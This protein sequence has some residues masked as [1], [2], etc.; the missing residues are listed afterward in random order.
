M[1]GG[2][3][4]D[5]ALVG[6]GDPLGLF[7]LGTMIV[8]RLRYGLLLREFP[9]AAFRPAAPAVEMDSVK[10][11]V[12]GGDKDFATSERVEP[13]SSFDEDEGA[14]CCS[15]EKSEAAESSDAF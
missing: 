15:R 12:G 5:W 1:Y 9:G 10:S 2:M 4:K 11:A 13:K 14:D 3:K 7:G 6:V 8:L